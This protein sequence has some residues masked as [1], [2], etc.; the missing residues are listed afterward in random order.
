MARVR[1]G[2][3]VGIG[4]N[5]HAQ[6]SLKSL[7]LVIPGPLDAIGTHLTCKVCQSHDEK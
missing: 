4:Y 2:S 6:F 3:G 1:F 5:M 7:G